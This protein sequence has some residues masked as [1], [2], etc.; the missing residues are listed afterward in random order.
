MAKLTVTARCHV[1]AW[2]PEGD[3]DRQAEKHTKATGHATAVE[4]RPT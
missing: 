2:Q 3:P 4:A 1:C